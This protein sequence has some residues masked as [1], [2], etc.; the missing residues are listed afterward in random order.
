MFGCS[1]ANH[2]SNFVAGQTH[3]FTCRLFRNASDFKHN[4]ARLHDR[5]PVLGRTFA[6]A[7]H[8]RERG[9]P[10]ARQAKGRAVRVCTVGGMVVELE[11]QYL[12][13]LGR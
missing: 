12:E 4:P 7:R 10:V 6:A 1:A 2:P 5:D 3:R 13:M 9:V 11:K 8:G